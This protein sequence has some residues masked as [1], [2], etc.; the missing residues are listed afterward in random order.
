MMKYSVSSIPLLAVSPCVRHLRILAVPAVLI[1]AA[2]IGVSLSGRVAGAGGVV[3]SADARLDLLPV[4]LL[5]AIAFL[6]S[7][8][9]LVS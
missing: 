1:A 6:S 8:P 4:L 3:R 2:S 9:T 5:A 7:G